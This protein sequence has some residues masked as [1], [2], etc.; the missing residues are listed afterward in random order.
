M[1]LLVS[2]ELSAGSHCF[3]LTVL[4]MMWAA[5]TVAAMSSITFP[6]VSALVSHSASPDQQGEL[7]CPSSC[8]RD[9]EVFILNLVSSSSFL[10]TSES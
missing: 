8:V 9:T 4:R 10:Q 7:T 1:F 6:A 2:V 3:F 5:G